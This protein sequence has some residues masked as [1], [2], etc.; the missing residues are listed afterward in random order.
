MSTLFYKQL[1][2]FESWNDSEGT[3]YV[4]WFYIEN[5]ITES[6]QSYYLPII[7]L[8]YHTYPSVRCIKIDD[9]RSLHKNPYAT[10]FTHSPPHGINMYSIKSHKEQWEE[11]DTSKYE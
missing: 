10:C 2:H 7:G 4:L 8:F 6:L 1:N 5:Y 11:D 9:A 3:Q